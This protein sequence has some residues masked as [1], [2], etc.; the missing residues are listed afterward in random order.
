MNVV[1]FNG[2]SQAK[3]I[4]VLPPQSLEGGC[5]FIQDVRPVHYVCAYDR[6]VMDQIKRDPSINYYTRIEHVH[7]HWK[8][9]TDPLMSGIN[10]GLLA[11]IVATHMNG[12]PIYILG[13]DWGLSNDS[14]F[15]Y[16][17]QSLR[18]YSNPMKKVL[19]KLS[20]RNPIYVVNDRVPDVDLPVITSLNFLAITYK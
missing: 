12:D 1:W 11:V 17:R 18:K 3:L 15:Q 13:C 19:K 14:V 2:P 5:N 7:A 20:Q 9:V 8:A 4:D 6:P 16:G 10:S